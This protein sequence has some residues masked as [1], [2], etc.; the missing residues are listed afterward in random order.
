MLV[1]NGLHDLY[2]RQAWHT[3][4]LPLLR[5]YTSYKATK[6]LTVD[7]TEFLA[8]VNT[9]LK[10]LANNFRGFVSAKTTLSFIPVVD[11]RHR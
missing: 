8:I 10:S 9:L 1:A 3:G 7:R 2:L 5:I 11:L 4:T 6:G